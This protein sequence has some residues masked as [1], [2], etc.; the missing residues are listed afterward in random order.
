MVSRRSGGFTVHHNPLEGADEQDEA[1]RRAP[2]EGW[3]RRREHERGEHGER[4]ERLKGGNQSPAASTMSELERTMQLFNQ[5]FA[6]S[7][8]KGGASE[9]K[10]NLDLGGL[11]DDNKDEVPPHIDAMVTQLQESNISLCYRLAAAEQESAQLQEMVTRLEQRNE[12]MASVLDENEAALLR[13]RV[14][15]SDVAEFNATFARSMDAVQAAQRSV[16]SGDPEVASS[17][18]MCVEGLARGHQQMKAMMV[19]QEN[20]ARELTACRDELRSFKEKAPASSVSATSQRDE[21]K[22]QEVRS[23]CITLELTNQKLWDIN[24]GLEKDRVA[25]VKEIAQVRITI[26]RRSTAPP[27]IPTVK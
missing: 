15:H 6:E 10:G 21:N 2:R 3:G 13:L 9:L 4:G 17:L 27:Q 19:Q 26:Y 20:T 5:G 12:A 25:M 14:Q 18:A 22:L 8:A 16:C 24:K 11:V 7:L 1:L 23:R